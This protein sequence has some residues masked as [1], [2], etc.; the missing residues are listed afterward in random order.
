MMLNKLLL[1]VFIL[2]SWSVFGQEVMTPELLLQVGRVSAIGFSDDGQYV[3]YSVKHFDVAKNEGHS[4]TYKI[5]VNGGSPEEVSRVSDFI[6]NDKI[7]PDGTHKIRSKEVKMDKIFGRDYYPELSQSDVMIYNDLNY[8]HWDQWEDGRYSHVFL[9]TRSDTGFDK[10]LDIMNGEPYDCPQKPFGGSGDFIWSPDGKNIVYVTK[11]SK[12]KEYAKSTNSDIYSY[13]IER[14]TT[15]NLTAGREG[16]DQSPAFSP[17][18][19]MAWLSMRSPGYE[20]DKNDIL[21]TN[22]DT[23]VNLTG[24]WDRTVNNF[25]WSN[26]GQKIFFT[27]AT[28]GT[29]Q[30]FEVNYSETS[31]ALPVIKQITSGRFDIRGIIGQSGQELVVSRTDMNHAVELYRVDIATGRMKQLTHVNDELYNSIQLSR[32]EKRMSKTTDDKDLLSWV[33]YPPDFD[34]QKKYPVLLYL[35]G[36]PQGALSQFYSFRWNF[37]LMAAHGYIVLAPNRRGMPGYGV[38]WNEQISKDYGG[39]CMKDYLSAIDDFTQESYV[40][41]SRIGAIGASFGGYSSF[42]LM[43]HH[44]GRFKTFVSHDGIFNWTSMYGTTEELWFVNWDLGGPYWEK[45]NA[46]A[47]K[48]YGDFNP[49]NFVDKWDTPILIIQGGI[50]YRVPIGQGLEAFQAAQLKGL[51][52][53]LLYFPH[54][55]H[56]VLKAQN[57]LIWHRQFYKWLDETL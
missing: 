26:D 18:G 42:Y 51:K 30:L 27:A 23:T 34:P 3:L 31:T 24:H 16:Y 46:D 28:N 10:G 22:G 20:S 1:P 55:N 40:D 9:Y 52:S 29:V 8:R 2:F 4:K 47:Q 5:S 11:K 49:V 44:Q 25:K 41:T 54:E 32:I 12:G 35:Q 6:H 17:K 36:G 38:K 48:A 7:S 43:G 45:D 37:Q 53:R 15:V 13:N 19:Q 50:D 14:K 33:I 21:V 57:S 56:W 39:Q